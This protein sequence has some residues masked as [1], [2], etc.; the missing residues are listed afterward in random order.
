MRFHAQFQGIG[1]VHE[2]TALAPFVT[3]FGLLLFPP[4]VRLARRTLAELVREPAARDLAIVGTVFLG[5]VVYVATQSLV[6]FVCVAI[7]AAVLLEILDEQGT[8]PRGALV[9]VGTAAIALGAAEIVFLRDP[10]GDEMH[11]MN[12]VFKLYFQAWALLALA[13]GPLVLEIVES[14]RGLVRPLVRAVLVAGLAASFCYPIA[15]IV[16]RSRALPDGLTLDGMAYLDREH[17]DDGAA[18]RWLSTHV[19]G[20]PVVLEATGD[21]YSYF[22]RVSANTGLPTVLGWANHEGVWR[23]ADPQIRARADDVNRLYGSTD[24][25]VRGR[26]LARY[27]IRYVF[28]GELERERFSDAALAR[29]HARPELFGTAYRSGSTEVLEVRQTTA[30]E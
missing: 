12:T 9:L 17:P 20:L 1:R 10:Y 28:F 5:A 23:G 19:S 13:F 24:D 11:R 2:R 27:G 30:S 26:L 16:I 25:D 4:V 3:V 14:S 6:L 29:L 7:L 22:A 18:I 21:P 15:V 8:S